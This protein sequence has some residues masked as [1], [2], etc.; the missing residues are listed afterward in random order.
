MP[1]VEPQVRYAQT[2]DGVNIAWFALG[3]GEPYLWSQAPPAAGLTDAWHNPEVRPI[4]DLI[5]GSL[6]LVVC[7][8]RGFGLSDRD[9]TDFSC[10]AMVRDLEAVVAA[11][12]LGPVILQTDGIMSIPAVRFAERHPDQV[13][14]LVLLNAMMSGSDLSDNWERLHRLATEDWD[15]A[16]GVLSSGNNTTVSTA[17]YEWAYE[18]IT[19]GASQEALVA[20]MAAVAEW[21]ASDV[22]DRV[23]TPALVTHMTPA[24]LFPLE[25]SRRLVMTL[26]NGRF[27]P[28]TEPDAAPR[29]DALMRAV[30]GFLGDVLPRPPR[31]Q[32]PATQPPSGTAVIIFTDIVD[33][34]A[35]TERH[36]DTA[37]RASSRALDDS[38]R[39]AM[40]ESGGSPL[41]GKVLGDGVLGVFQSAAR[42]IDCA[43]ACLVAAATA[44]LELHVGLHAGDVIHED[45]TVYG[46][47]VNIAARVCGI[48]QPGEVLVSSTV[49]DLARTSSD[50]AF[51]DRGEHSLKGV[52]D[53][54][55]VF[56]VSRN[57]HD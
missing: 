24:P 45:G 31:E 17:T 47:A 50:V 51:D 35:L 44:G 56:A 39:D 28:I 2:S 7:D 30:V 53:A 20:F 14:A 32:K 40:R 25:A 29:L 12:E 36:G 42:A 43:S 34:T 9:V 5:A 23:E 55:R 46:G 8:P 38:I 33:S 1:A 49:R 41:A 11:A 18:H 19:R 10:D 4:F 57:P 21:D 13:R 26:P 22:A 37:F 15:F 27:A 16:R 52:A 3:S 6:R 54:V 48:S